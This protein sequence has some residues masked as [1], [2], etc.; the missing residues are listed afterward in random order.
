METPTRLYLVAKPQD[1][2]YFQNLGLRYTLETTFFPPAKPNLST[3]S[4]FSG[5]NGAYHS[6]SELANELKSLA[7]KFP[8]IC[9]LEEIGQS[10]EGRSIFALKISDKAAFNEAEPGI[11]F[12]GCHHA[13]E[14]ISVEV[15]LYLGRYL[16][17]NYSLN[18]LIQKLIDN[19]QIWIVPLVNPDGLEYSIKF[20]RYWRKNRRLNSDGSFGVDLNRNYGFNWGIDNKGSSPNPASEIYRG[21]APFSEPETRAVRDLFLRIPFQALVSYHSY[22]Q[23]ILF[24]WGFTTNPADKFQLLFNLAKRMSELM[25]SVYGRYYAFGQASSLLYLTNGD[26][27][28]WAYGVAGIPAFTVELPPIDILYGGFFNS[29]SDIQPIFEENLRAALDLIQWGIDNYEFIINGRLTEKIKKED[30]LGVNQLIKDIKR[31]KN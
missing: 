22:S 8:S 30:T 13:R 27:T 18:P 10:V 12:L 2:T 26:T 16:V 4:P 1:L 24:P 31:R 5:G 17:N 19:S 25:T 29:E 21:T 20:Y 3:F 6:Y 7:Q 28:D 11:L 15:P 9:Q 14:W 23:V